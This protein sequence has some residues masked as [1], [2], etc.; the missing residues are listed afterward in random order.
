M[1]SPNTLAREGKKYFSHRFPPLEGE[2]KGGV[3]AGFTLIEILVVI[4]IFSVLAAIGLFFSMDVYRSNSVSSE[5]DMIMSILQKA[6]SQAI[7]NINEKPHGVRFISGK[8]IVF[9]GIDCDATGQENPA[10]PSVHPI[11]DCVKFDQ[12]T[13]DSIN[14]TLTVTDGAKTFTIEINSQ[15]RIS[16]N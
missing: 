11:D 9:E 1:K 4:G 14:K 7:N 5:R 16:W 12:L 10:S 8:Y 6:R 13:G 2:G 3:V 15:G